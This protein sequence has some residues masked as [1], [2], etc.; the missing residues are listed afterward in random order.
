MHG[1][2][3]I[4]VAHRRIGIPVSSA[5]LSWA[6]ILFRYD[7]F[8]MFRHLRYMSKVTLVEKHSL[9]ISTKIATEAISNIRTVAGLSKMT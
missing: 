5:M 4:D 2:F 3:S 9:G 8:K 6:L 1:C 7:Y